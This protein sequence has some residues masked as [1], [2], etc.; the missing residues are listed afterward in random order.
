MSWVP[1]LEFTPYKFIAQAVLGLVIHIEQN[2]LYTMQLITQHSI[3]SG[4][5]GHCGHCEA[6]WAIIAPTIG[7]ADFLYQASISFWR[8]EGWRFH[9]SY[10]CFLVSTLPAFNALIKSPTLGSPCDASFK[11][12]DGSAVRRGP[13]SVAYWKCLRM[14]LIL[15]IQFNSIQCNSIQLNS[16]QFNSIQFNSLLIWFN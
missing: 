16:I 9:R 2:L 13:R 6:S 3:S 11:M 7:L 8:A 14:N 4:Q 15:L 5:N 10:N 12:V 1:P